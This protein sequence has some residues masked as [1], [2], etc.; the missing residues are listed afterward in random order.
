[1]WGAK[2]REEKIIARRDDNLAVIIKT[3]N[4]ICIRATMLIAFQIFSSKKKRFYN[5]FVECVSVRASAISAYDRF[6]M[7]NHWTRL[8]IVTFDDANCERDCIN[9]WCAFA[10]PHDQ[11]AMPFM[12]PAIFYTLFFRFLFNFCVCSEN[13]LGFPTRGGYIFISNLLKLI[14]W[15]NF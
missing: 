15:N 6:S 7:A 10:L 9:L 5:P 2:E 11:F 14:N 8:E 1:V 3:L 12:N 4:C 13:F